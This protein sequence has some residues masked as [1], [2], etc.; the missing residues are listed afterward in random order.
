MKAAKSLQREWE[1]DHCNHIQLKTC[2]NEIRCTKCFEM[3]RKF[4][5]NW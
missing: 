3:I 2:D 4:D 5:L 1:R